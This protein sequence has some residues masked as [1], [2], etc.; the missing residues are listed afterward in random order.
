MKQSALLKIIYGALTFFF[1]YAIVFPVMAVLWEGVSGG[2]ALFWKTYQL[3]MS[4]LKNSLLLSLPVAI[5]SV[6]LGFMAA[7]TLQR[8]SF[9]GNKLLKLLGL[10]PIIHPPFVGSISFVMLFGKRG[11]ITYGL[12]GIEKSPYGYVGLF[13]L[14]VIGLGAMAY[15]LLS[16]GL[17]KV[18]K[19]LEEAA[20]N[21]GKSAEKTFLTVTLPMLKPELSST[22]L[23]VFL[24][25][26]ADFGT[27]LIIG[28]AYQ[29]LASQ[30]Y[31]QITGRYDLKS[32]AVLGV[33]L[34]IPCFVAFFLHKKMNQKGKLYVDEKNDSSFH[35]FHIVT[36]GVFIG[37]TSLFMGFVFLKYGF[38]VLGAFT[39]NWGRDYTPT[40]AHVQRLFSEDLTPI[41]NSIK[42]SV[43]VAFLCGLLGMLTA[44]FV[45][46]KFR[47]HR[48]VDWMVTLPA[49]VP[50]ILFG[51]SYL[52][53]FKYPLLFFGKYYM[54]EYKGIILLGTSFIVYLICISRY[55]NLAMRTS[56][57]ELA[58]M[59]P[60]LEEASQNLGKGPLYTFFRIICPL[61]KEPFKSSFYKV[62]AQ[63]MTTLG[64]IVFL[65]LPRNKVMVQK[66]FQII[67]GAEIGV[68]AVFSLALSFT[69]LILLGVFYLL[70]EW[71]PKRRVRR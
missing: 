38:I 17:K 6:I 30:L 13:I 18:D 68:A 23:L 29:T 27:P 28:G 54:V 3:G 15:I 9:R 61:L 7:F 35:G 69:T 31:I 22:F 65:L 40:L 19:S 46:K 43:I 47:F 56:L 16:A 36:K 64:A 2:E 33:F 12:L 21:L 8:L 45:H 66:I 1:L 59:P 5:C 71:R 26:L 55:T 58:H 42:L 50:G 51:I 11:L 24:A 44:Y 4:S 52:L 41:W 14:Q 49:A 60:Q 62:F 67:T 39:K 70:L 10:L 20:M 48:F 32:A 34:L 57:A 37:I 53:L 63:T 25:S